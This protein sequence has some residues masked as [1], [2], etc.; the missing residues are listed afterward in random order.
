MDGEYCFDQ[1][2]GCDNKR[3]AGIPVG[4]T[5]DLDEHEPGWTAAKSIWKIHPKYQTPY[6][7]TIVTGLLVAIPSLFM[8]SSK[9]TDLTSIGTLFAFVLVSGGV[10]TLPK[11]DDSVQRGFKLPYIN[12]KF[13]VPLLAAIFIYLSWGRIVEAFGNLGKDSLQEILFLVYV[14]MAVILAIASFIKNFSLIP[15][16]G[17][18][19]CSYLLIEIPATSWIWFFAWMGIGLAIYFLYGYRKSQF[20]KSDE[21]RLKLPVQ[22]ED[23][24]SVHKNLCHKV[25]NRNFEHE[26]SD[27]RQG[28]RTAF[29]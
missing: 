3:V 11:L 2:S 6:F 24:D 27:W 26:I 28:T 22:L 13:I 14:L 4:T 9:M 10:L 7:S 16:L 29:Q 20:E 5:P 12:G 23:Y 8:Q 18:L 25:F 15:I 1:C 21:Q 17:V 19:F